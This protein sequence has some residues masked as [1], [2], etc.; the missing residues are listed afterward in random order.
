[1]RVTLC[2]YRYRQAQGT[3]LPAHRFSHYVSLQALYRRC[4]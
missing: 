2:V 3:V 1:M 4:S